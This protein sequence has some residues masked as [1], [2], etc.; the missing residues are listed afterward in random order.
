MPSEEA[1]TAAEKRAVLRAVA[2]DLRGPDADRPAEQL[3]ATVQRVSDLYDPGEDRT[4][5]SIYRETGHI[6]R[7]V[8][9]ESD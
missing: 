6:R 2:A 1:F 8:A 7:S 5:E 9:D 4:P 3:A